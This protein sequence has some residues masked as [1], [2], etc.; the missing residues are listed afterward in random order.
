MASVSPQ[1]RFLPPLKTRE[2]NLVKKND[3]LKYFMQTVKVS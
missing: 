3:F 2:E 1:N